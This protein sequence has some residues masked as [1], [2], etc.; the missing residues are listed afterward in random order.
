[1]DGELA[2][3][4]SR[5]YGL[6]TH[7]QALDV[8]LS[9]KA[10]KHRVETGRW[11]PHHVGVYAVA[12]A[13]RP[14]EQRVLAACLAAGAGAVASHRCAAQLW[15]LD[16]A[17]S[18][19]VEISVARPGLHRLAGVSLH[20]STELDRSLPTVQAGIPVTAPTR[21]LVDLGAVVRPWMVERALDDALAR[22]LVTLAGVRRELETVARKG[23]RGPGVLRDLLS[24][25]ADAAGLAESPLEVRMLRLC[26]D[27]HVPEPVCQFEVREALR[28][29]GR[30]DFAFPDRRLA[31]EVDGYEFHSTL[32]AFQRDRARQ[33]DLVA[34]GW[35]VLRFTWGDVTRRPERVASSI[36]RLLVAL[37]AG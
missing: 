18:G 11:R 28:L 9:G 5:Q 8:G 3:T 29:I 10:V 26:R 15:S 36:H 16:G 25:R 33:N 30:V 19:A 1:M 35:T 27:H 6:I 14:W 4:A 32:T 2:E 21:T 24:D 37:K 22:R 12:G 20:R 31:I 7:A 17:T 23:R 34:A 13:P